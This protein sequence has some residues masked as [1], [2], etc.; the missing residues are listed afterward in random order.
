M[1]I[2]F[3][4]IYFPPIAGGE[5]NNAYFLAKGL[6]KKHEV[7]VFTL[8]KKGKGDLKRRI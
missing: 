2:A 8:N 4:T 7:H 1:K 6:A 3:V 5:G